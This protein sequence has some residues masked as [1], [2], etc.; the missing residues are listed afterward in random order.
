MRN[1]ALSLVLLLSSVSMLAGEASRQL[2][3]CRELI[4]AVRP[5][6]SEGEEGKRYLDDADRAYRDCRAEK[7][8]IEVRVDALFKYGLATAARERTQTAIAAY[9]EAI[10]L[11]DRA[12]SRPS[13]RM[14]EILDSLAREESRSGLRAE[15]LE[16]AQRA[17]NLR[18]ERYGRSSAEAAEGMVHSAMVHVT[19]KDYAATEKLLRQAIRVAEK[20]C[21]PTC[22]TLV[23]AYSG[24]AVLHDAQGNQAEARKYEELAMEAVPP[25][26]TSAIRR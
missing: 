3:N 2:A 6:G 21:G 18:S 10:D 23:D 1:T 26:T 17:A 12:G 16:H 15:A 7:F 24:M 19:F 25:S 5:P 20:A 8:P 4:V 22:A 14:I 13:P 11:L 9:R